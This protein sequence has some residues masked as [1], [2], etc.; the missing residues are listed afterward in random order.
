MLELVFIQDCDSGGVAIW[1]PL[2]VLHHCIWV[3][4]E[5]LCHGV[6]FLAS[7]DISFNYCG[8][9]CCVWL[10]WLLIFC[11]SPPK[12]GFVLVPA[13]LGLWLGIGPDCS[14]KSDSS[15]CPHRERLAEF[16]TGRPVWPV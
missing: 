2:L 12:G 3:F 8:L 5:M 4:L 13:V 11:S 15:V 14:V 6:R 9:L 16:A 10:A 7:E 1:P